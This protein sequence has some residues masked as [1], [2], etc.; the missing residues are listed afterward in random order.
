MILTV[1]ANSALDRVI[2]ID[3]LEAGLT[4]RSKRMVDSIG[5]KGFDTSIVLQELGADNLALGIVAGKTGRDLVQLLESYGVRHD[6]LWV[7]GETRIAH[8]IIETAS[9]RDSHITS[10]GYSVTSADCAAFTAKFHSQLPAAEWVIAS[11]SLPEGMPPGFYGDICAA[12]G[13]LHIPILIDCPDKPA[14]LALPGYP[15]ILKMNAGEFA[16]TFGV[17]GGSLAQLRKT[18]AEVR[19]AHAVA[20]LVITCGEEGVLAI[21]AQGDYQA[22]SPRQAAVNAAGAGDAVSGCLAWRFS[23][24]DSWDK[25]LQ[26]AAAAGAAVALTERTAECRM[27]D[28]ER[29]YPQVAVRRLN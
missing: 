24:G 29:I 11:G 26:W 20:N 3:Y 4:M 19:E 21:T 10:P 14:L 13:E 27:A 15:T 5:G 2:F 8:V 12:A 16:H 9:Y 6:L 18:A 17:E 25:A 7:A 1:T 28:V 22:V 23:Q